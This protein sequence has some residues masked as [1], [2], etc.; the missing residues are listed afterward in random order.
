MA[1]TNLE[2]HRDMLQVYSSEELRNI[3]M[4]IGHTWNCTESGP[5]YCKWLNHNSH[6]AHSISERQKEILGIFP[7][8]TVVKD[9]FLCLKFKPI[10]LSGALTNALNFNNTEI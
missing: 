6:F 4:L 10:F 3:S 1:E 2:L 5:H 7:H 8:V 9:H